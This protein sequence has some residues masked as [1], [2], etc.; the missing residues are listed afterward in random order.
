MIGNVWEWTA[1]PDH[2]PRR[3]EGDAERDSTGLDP[4]QRG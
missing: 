2:A 3:A 4:R 1:D